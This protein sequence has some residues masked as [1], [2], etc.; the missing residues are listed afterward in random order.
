MAF[1]SHVHLKD[2]DFTYTI[3][4]NIKRYTLKDNT[5]EET[6][7]GNFQ[8]SRMLEE[9]PN[10]GNG[11]LLKIIINKDL[12][13][14]KINITD[15]SGLHLVNLFKKDA[16]PVIQEKFYFLMDSLVDRDIF[17]KEQA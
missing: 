7:V 4:P 13:G 8:L 1:D 15:K 6:K 14:F 9:V 16:N 12:T 10:S 2:C 3:S 17:E 11:F 5:F